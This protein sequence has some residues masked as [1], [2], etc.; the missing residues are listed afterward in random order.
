MAGQRQT[1]H[2]ELL[3]AL[4]SAVIAN[5]ELDNWVRL[6]TWQYSYNPYSSTGSLLNGGGRF[7]YGQM[8]DSTRETPF[9]ALYVSE[10]LDT[11]YR[12]KFGV[13]KNAGRGA[14]DA[15]D[16]ALTPKAS[17]TNVY[18]RGTIYDLVDIT[19]PSKL[20]DFCKVFAK[21]KISQEV[22]DL[23]TKAGT[24]PIKI[25]SNSQQLVAS[26]Y[27][28]NWRGWATQFGIPSN[29]Q[30]FGRLVYEAGY[31]GVLYRSVRGRGRCVAL[32][33]ENLAYN[34]S[35]M[36]LVDEP[37]AL[38]I[39]TVIKGEGWADTFRAPKSLSVQ[40]LH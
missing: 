3:E 19:K 29:S 6:I 31:S 10:D 17:T 36:Y 1:R 40:T 26:F 28:S 9:P 5:H 15:L 33:P 2:G 39:P 4:K 23:A 7:N 30:I 25:I 34:E 32:F 11:A 16:L 24:R 18:L 8:I 14:L 13:T 37:P 38:S 12:E 27:Q 35:E 22:V 20:A 21:F